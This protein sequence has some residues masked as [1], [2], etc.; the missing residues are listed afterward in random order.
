M[1]LHLLLLSSLLFLQWPLHGQHHISRQTYKAVLKLPDS[2]AINQGSLTLYNL[3]KVQVKAVY[4]NRNKSREAFKKAV[5]EKT[6]YPYESFWAGYVGNSDVYFDDVLLP[7]L[8]DSLPMIENKARLFA[9]GKIDVFFRQMT[10]RMQAECGYYPQGKW[11]VAFGH[12]VTDMGGFGGGVMVLDLTHSMSTLE[13]TK[14]ILPHEFTHQ[15]F[16]FI[17]QADTTAH[18]L[19][20]CIN[21]GFAVYVHQKM[22]GPQYALPAYLLYSEEAFQFCVQREGEIFKKLKPFLLTNNPDHARA[23]ADRGYKVFKDKGPGAI[24]YFVG[25]KICEAYI[26][27][28]GPDSW[29]DIFT[30]PVREILEKSG[31]DPQ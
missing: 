1:K 19:Y 2:V 9:R 3:F 26:L 20:R 18:G 16:D 14:F 10:D 21:E 13:H 8:R 25:Y 5:L 23:L 27:K 28:N 24:G 22:L 17:N 4:E 12:G 31:Y 7:L 15:I 30:M 29:K 11:Y 6:Y